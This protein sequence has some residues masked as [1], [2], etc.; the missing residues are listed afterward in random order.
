MTTDSWLSKKLLA[1]S[2]GAV[3]FAGFA[4]P[5][6]GAEK[7]RYEDIPGLSTAKEVF[8]EYRGC[9]VVT[10]DGKKYTG[11]RMSIQRDHVRI[12]DAKGY[13]DIPQAQIAR[14]E[15]R[16]FG[17]FFHN[18]PENLSFALVCFQADSNLI[19]FPC[20]FTLLPVSIGF[21]A[22]SAPVYLALDAGTLFI[23]P[24]VY[25]IVR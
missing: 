4:C 15:I 11:R 17:R 21:T 18:I 24:K 3:L 10:V 19:G 2:I 5:A 13:H 12:I 8:F 14:I 16:Q 25:E 6:R 22:V 20:L 9:K 1:L 23:P 7:I